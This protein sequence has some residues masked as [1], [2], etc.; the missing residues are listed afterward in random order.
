MQIPVYCS[1][2]VL[3]FERGDEK[4]WS[5]GSETCPFIPRRMDLIY[6]PGQTVKHRV[7]EV[8]IDYRGG[9]TFFTVQ[10]ERE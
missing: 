6:V 2:F 8:L 3:E 5:I 10:V 4:L 7:T 9:Q 1:E